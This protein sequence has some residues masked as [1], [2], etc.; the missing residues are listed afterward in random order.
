MLEYALKQE[1]LVNNSNNS[2][3]YVTL[4]H[5]NFILQHSKMVVFKMLPSTYNMDD[6][7]L[8]KDY[9]NSAFAKERKGSIGS[10]VFDFMAH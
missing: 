10:Y 1:R 9:R 6:H 3:F 5:L 7:V 4:Q 2:V 8:L